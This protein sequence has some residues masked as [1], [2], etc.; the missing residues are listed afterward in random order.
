MKIAGRVVEI[1]VQSTDKSEKFWSD[2]VMTLIT[3]LQTHPMDTR[4]FVKGVNSNLD[5]MIDS[6]DRFART[7]VNASQ[8]GKLS[9]NEATKLFTKSINDSNTA[10]DVEASATVK[11]VDKYRLSTA[12]Y[13]RGIFGI[14]MTLNAFP[15][16]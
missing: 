12:D 2:V 13:A 11:T 5:S 7:N 16:H 9:L 4:E 1:L 10:K 6:A 8:A 3:Q 15:A 14:L